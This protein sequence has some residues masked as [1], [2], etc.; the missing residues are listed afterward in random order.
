M[1]AA[2]HHAR[3]LNADGSPRC[4]WPNVARWRLRQFGDVL[5]ASCLG[6]V[7]VVRVSVTSVLRDRRLLLILRVH[8]E[9]DLDAVHR[10][11]VRRFAS[12]DL[13][14]QGA[15]TVALLVVT[16]DEAG[17]VAEAAWR[18]GATA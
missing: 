3:G 1:R 10:S 2:L 16:D 12:R 6:V 8:P 15:L 18:L 7:G 17:R 13:Y 14:V 4:A 9:A 11:A 5:A